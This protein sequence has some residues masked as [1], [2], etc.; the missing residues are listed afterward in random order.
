MSYSR[1]STP[2]VHVNS[3]GWGPTT[4]PEQYVG[5]PFSPFGKGDRLGKAAD[6]IGRDYG[7]YSRE[8]F[9]TL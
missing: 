6:F 7:R 1:F 5:V 2:T 8:F 3:E 9:N 4:L